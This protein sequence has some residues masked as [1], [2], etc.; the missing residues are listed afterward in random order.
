MPR[1]GVNGTYNLPAGTD[2]QAPNT[3]ISSSMFNGAMDDIEQAFNTPTPV[4]YGGTNSAT[5]QGAINTLLNGTTFVRSNGLRVADSTD[6]TKV[7]RFNVAGVTTGAVRDLTVPDISGKLIVT[8]GQVLSAAEQQAVRST[9]G[10]TNGYPMMIVVDQKTAGTEG[11]SSVAGSQVRTLNTV[12]V[13]EIG[14]T[15]SS[16]AVTLT[17][18][19]YYVEADA[20]AFLSNSHQIVVLLSGAAF[21]GSTG[22]AEYSS[23]S[24]TTQTRSV[25]SVR[26]NA[27][28][29]ESV[30]I[31][32]RFS[33]ARA[34]N[35]L[36]VAAN[37]AGVP[38]IYAR[39]KIWKLT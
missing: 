13:N 15:L 8:G 10:L 20:P 34:T 38:E 3:T 36:G 33:A 5:E 12:I 26:V 22:T 18:G 31:L 19:L 2:T 37:N 21:N 29:G 30:S 24:G 4:S 32:H 28:A 25:V 1:S 14:G 16:N 7:M 23:T 17:A 6:N 9:I 11:G 27:G 35:G 39:L